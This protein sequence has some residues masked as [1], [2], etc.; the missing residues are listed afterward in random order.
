MIKKV[1]AVITVV[2]VIA[3]GLLAYSFFKAPEEASAPLE[4]VPVVVEEEA[5]QPEVE[6]VEETE[7]VENPQTDPAIAEAQAP[8]A[9][10][11]VNE[12]TANEETTNEET[13]ASNAPTIFEIVST[14]SEA[15]FI[16]DEVLR[17]EAVTVVGVTDQV[18]GQFAIDQADLSR[19]QMGPIVVNARTLATDNDFRNR[20][21]KNQILETDA[22]EFITFTPTEVMGLSGSGASGESYNFQIVGDLTIRDVT[23]PVTFEATATPLSDVELEGSASVTILYDD[24]GLTIPAAQAVSA[25]DDEVKLEIDF[26]ATAVEQSS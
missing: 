3:L 22:Y 12:E 21:I 20:A 15:R 5:S 24:F 8:S 11:P 13:V 25:V 4:A 6:T 19:V 10:E 9:E 7:I 16:I 26:V 14:E 23:R 18:A 2:V 1:L 17:N